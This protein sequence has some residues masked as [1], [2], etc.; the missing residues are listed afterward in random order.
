MKKVTI[1]DYGCGNILSVQRAFEYC[2]SETIISTH[3]KDVA[4]ADFLVLPGVGAFENGMNGLIEREL[5]VAIKSFIEKERPF[6]GICLGM[7]MMLTQSHEFGI[8]QGLD[9]IE[10]QVIQIENT[11]IGDV[12]HKIPH[13]GW[14][15]LYLPKTGEA[16]LWKDTVL[17]DIL[18]Q[19]DV[20]FVHSFTAQTANNQHRLADTYYGGRLVSAII[21]KDYNYGCQF[22]PEKS[23]QVGLKILKNFL[24]LT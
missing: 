14:N 9:I 21:K 20:Y 6:L 12:P 19:S 23:G 10:G 13:I 11:D 2:G 4:N 15:K 3:P 16:G 24:E 1:I 22:H 18:I 17:D 5:D 8:N 7:Q